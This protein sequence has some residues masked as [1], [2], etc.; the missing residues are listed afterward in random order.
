MP[1]K[2][3]R[4]L[5]ILPLA[6]VLGGCNMIILHPSGIPG[7]QESSLLIVSAV[8]TGLIIIPVLIAIAVIAIRYRHSNDKARYEPEWDHSNRL[9]LLMWAAPILIITALGAATWVESHKLDPFHPLTQTE[10]ASNRSSSANAGQV[11]PVK[12]LV[13][14]VTSLEWKWLF[15]YP[16]YGIATVNQVAAPIN[17]PITFNLTAKS[18]MNSLFIPA[19]AGMIYNMPNMQTKLH[20]EINKVGNYRGFSGNFS[21]HGFTN[22]RFRFLG[23]TA[24]GFAHWVHV[25]KTTGTDLSR[26]AYLELAKPSSSVPVHYYSHYMPG[27]YNRILNRCVKKDQLCLYQVMAIDAHGGRPIKG[28]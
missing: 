1:A 2:I 13:I 21:G 7:K 20:A 10:T 15:F 4:N 14:D 3:L 11:S 25:V 18:M 17:V 27:L 19:L 9:E 6:I 26:Q 23:L 8:L 22:M 12:P 16:R 5:L 24:K 28:N